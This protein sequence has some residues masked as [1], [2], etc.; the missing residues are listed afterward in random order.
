MSVKVG[1]VFYAFIPVLRGTPKEKYFVIVCSED[2]VRFVLINTRNVVEVLGNPALAPT[3]VKITPFDLPRL[4]YESWI[5]C[6]EL[7]GGYTAEELASMVETEPDAFVGSLG[8][9]MLRKILIAIEISTTIVERQ[10]LRC[11]TAI[12]AVLAELG[13]QPE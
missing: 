9:D 6:N 7:L 11:V 13:D 10:K 1:D 2:P 12:R 5:G 4:S 8:A 3:Q